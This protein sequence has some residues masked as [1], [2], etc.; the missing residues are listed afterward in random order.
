M[1]QI[2][3]FPWRPPPES[4]GLTANGITQGRGLHSVRSDARVKDR[5]WEAGFSQLLH[6]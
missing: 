2:P 6:G 5:L 4:L 3:A 1:L